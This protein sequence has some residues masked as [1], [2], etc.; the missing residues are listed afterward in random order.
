[1]CARVK[2]IRKKKLIIDPV[3]CGGEGMDKLNGAKLLPL[4]LVKGL[5]TQ[6]VSYGMLQLIHTWVTIR[7]K[8]EFDIN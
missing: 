7:K 3:W 6:G 2:L 8:N 1:M 4:R 5:T